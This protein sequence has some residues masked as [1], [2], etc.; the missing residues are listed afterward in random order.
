MGRI[1]PEARSALR[2]LVQA[3]PG[4][5][6]PDAEAAARAVVVDHAAWGEQDTDRPPLVAPLEAGVLLRRK[7]RQVYA[8][9]S[10]GGGPTERQVDP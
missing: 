1:G 7:L 2:K 8:S 5:S 6:R 4:P 9:R 3:P 10:R